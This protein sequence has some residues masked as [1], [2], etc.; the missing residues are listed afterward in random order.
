MRI[1]EL[2]LMAFGPFTDSIID[3]HDGKEGFH[4]IYGLNE[5]GKS[6]A[7]RA[8]RYMLYGIPERSTDNFLHPYSKMRIGGTIRSGN[9]EVLE[10][11]RRKGRDNTLRTTDDISIIEEMELQRFLGGVDAELFSTMFGIGYE[12]LVRGG[13][14]IIQGGGNLGRLIFSAGSGIANLREVQNELQR[15]ADRLFK[16]AGQKPT[17]NE[18]LGRLN[19]IRKELRNAQLPGQEWVKHDESLRKAMA[20]KSHVEAKLSEKYKERNRLYR[21]REAMPLIAEHKELTNEIKDYASA[22]LLPEEFAENR[23]KLLTDLS[24]A[25]REKRTALKNIESHRQTISGLEISH[26]LLHNADLVEEIHR[27]LGSQR[28]AAKDRI[29]LET[30]RNTL[31]REAKETLLNLRDDLTLEEAEKLRIKK[32]EA[33]LVQDLGA[34]YERIITRIEDARDKLPELTREISKINNDLENLDAPLSIDELQ[35][36]LAEAE[37]YGPLEK[38]N[39]TEQTEIQN[40]L[41]TIALETD[42]LGVK[43]RPLEKLES[44]PVPFLETI[45][46]FE[47]RFDVSGRELDDIDSEIRKTKN[48]LIDIKRQIETL[49]LEQEVPTEENLQKAR[50]RRDQGWQ[51]ISRKLNKMAISNEE[52]NR[53]LEKTSG[54]TTLGEAFEADIKETDAISDRLRREA[55]HVASKVRLSAD[56]NNHQDQLQQLEKKRETAEKNRNEISKEW[57]EIWQP[58]GINPRSPR[59]MENWAQ[60]FRSLIEKVKEYRSRQAKI[61]QLK[62]EI[63]AHR[64]KL[65]QCFLSFP[66]LPDVGDEPLVS[67][68]KR[69]Q[70]FIKTEKEL[71]NERERLSREKSGKENELAIATA[72]L[73]TSEQELVTWQNKWEKAVQ[74]I[75]IEAKSV[76][77]QA[78]VVMEELKSLFDKLKEAKILQQRMNGIDRDADEF[79]RKVSGLVDIVATDLIDRSADEAALELQNR[80]KRSRDAWS[81]KETLEKQLDQEEKRLKK[82]TDDLLQIDTHLKNMCK[83]ANCQSSDELPEA[84][85]RSIRRRQL[86]TN[87]KNL[88]DQLHK[89]S[90][91]AAVD[92][93]I[94]EVL[95]VDPDGIDGEINRLSDEIDKLNQEKSLLDQTIGSERT[96]LSKMDGSAKAADLAEEIQIILGGLGDN[97]EQYA[98]LVIANKVLS[99][100]IERFRDKN[101]GPILMKASTLFNRITGSSFEGIR[102]E[103]EETGQPVIVGLR[104]GNK[105][106][107]KVEGMSDG[108]ADQLFLALRLAGLETYIEKNE[109]LPFIID[110]ILIKFDNERATA[111]LQILAELSKKTQVIFFTHHQHMVDLATKNIS[112]SVLFRHTLSN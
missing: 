69:A 65:I 18:A 24:I 42:K 66:G 107:V 93:F 32:A 51:L 96:E 1:D 109:P 22:V 104:P 84:E 49:Q 3:L 79:V 43:S 47:N 44:L 73:K 26:E 39:R 88:N 2:R 90:G 12:D 16:P 10:L 30:R 21:I 13:K 45:R 58:S 57:I 9:G 6:S 25:E 106:I 92:D 85:R 62:Y 37:D 11:I 77:A 29:G 34:Q 50:E 38:L 40:L 112:S 102:A 81:K 100:A 86:E 74:P 35:I 7:L 110:D 27:E 5:A 60:D 20:C 75:G 71:L 8:L 46:V 70:S 76:P 52:L 99:Q 59:E 48:T 4:I 95:A 54:P 14:E 82:A 111:T 72:R 89:L 63:E 31:R 105:E 87:L 101:Q 64:K 41:T 68:I 15:A 33:V 36:V 98:R 108:T 97:V 103:F 78:T 17:I 83:E 28:K 80:L 61:N 91:G 67:L 56:L 94:I 55:D 23:R 53:Y 19:K